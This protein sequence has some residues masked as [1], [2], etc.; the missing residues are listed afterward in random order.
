MKI[1]LDLNKVGQAA[2]KFTKDNPILVIGTVV[3]GYIT[4]RDHFL[5]KSI[6]RDVQDLK[7]NDLVKETIKNMK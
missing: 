5:I 6:K 4:L 2:L 1:N 3:V 7:N